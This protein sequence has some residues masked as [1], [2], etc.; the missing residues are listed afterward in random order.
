MENAAF[1]N[2]SS[3]VEASYVVQEIQGDLQFLVYKVFLNG[4]STV[5]MVLFQFSPDVGQNLIVL[6]LIHK[7]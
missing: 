6:E 1:G 2:S 4:C 5:E 7:R 3:S